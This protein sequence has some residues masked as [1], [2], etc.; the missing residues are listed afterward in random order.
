MKQVVFTASVLSMAVSSALAAE[1]LGVIEV[2]STR[3]SDVS[4]EE[5]KSAD[6]AEALT[7]KVPS[8]SLVRRSG[9][10]NDIILR[11]Q[12]KDNINI[13][14]DNAKVYGAC[15]NRMD[16]PTSHV[17]TNTIDSIEIIEGPYD[18]ENFGTLS[19]AVKVTTLQPSE[20]LNGEVSLNAGSFN[21]L[22]AAATVS[23]GNDKVRFLLSASNESSDQYKDGDGNTFADQIDNANPTTIPMMDPR[24]KDEYRDIDAYEKSAFL[25]KLYFNFTENQELRLSYT[26]NRSDDVLYPSSPMD[27]LF[28]DS[29]IL[30]IEYTAKDLARFSKSLDVQYYS[31]D[32]EHPM[33]NFYRIASGPDSANELISYLTTDTQGVRI[34]DSFDISSSSELTLGIDTSLRN[35]DGAYEGKGTRAMLTGNKSID[36]VDTENAGVFAQ[37]ENRYSNLSIKA[38]I[39]IDDTSITPAGSLGQQ[40]NDYS[41]VG[42]NVFVNYQADANTRYFAGVGSASRVPDARELYFYSP[43]MIEIGTPTLD[44]TTNTQVDLG[45]EKNHNRFNIKTTLFYSWLD[46]YIYFNADKGTGMSP[47][48]NA[49]ENI[50]ATMY[51]FDISGAYFATDEVYVDFGLAYQRGRKDQALAGQTDTDLAEV[52][53]LKAN[54]ALNYDYS[55]RNT[56][57][58]SLVAADAW[59]NFD[60]DNGEQYISGYGIVNVKVRHYVTRSL[61]LTA[62]IDNITDKTYAV[63]NTY[64]DLTLLVA[65][66]GDVILMNEPGRY[67][68]VN[69]TYRF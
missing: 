8:I 43:M 31:S 65:G 46:D 64:K 52:P 38:G 48:G 23:G 25:G 28:D 33:S 40:S 32:V 9:I 6:L 60:S 50:D 34:K 62:G 3:L 51:G 24:Y 53:P 61:E 22:K 59:D 19:G 21:Y 29:N 2:E 17:L 57:S 11:G 27:A 49:F 15:P 69:G 56:A 63:T 35:W 14:I 4:G 66:S 39:R 37:I 54:V 16:P 5:V 58:I 36:D 13:L 30:N 55:N 42:A 41:G 12:K 45:L 20:G 7:R 67:L 18:V 47:A 68:Y 26:A 10:A 44:K 1:E